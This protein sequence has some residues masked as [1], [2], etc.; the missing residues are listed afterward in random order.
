LPGQERPVELAYRANRDGALSRQN[1]LYPVAARDR[2]VGLAKDAAGGTETS[3]GGDHHAGLFLGAVSDGVQLVVLVKQARVAF[4]SGLA[5]GALAGWA[6]AA[7]RQDLHVV[8]PLAPSGPAPARTA[9][10]D[11]AAGISQRRR[12][13]AVDDKALQPRLY[14]RLGFR[15]AEVQRAARPAD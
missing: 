4:H 12:I 5:A 3:V 7:G 6:L 10:P 13:R 2:L 14:H 8:E 15:D 9:Q 1:R 11:G